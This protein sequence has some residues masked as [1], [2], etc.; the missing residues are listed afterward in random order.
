MTYLIATHDIDQ[1]AVVS[2]RDQRAE[3]G[4]PG[5]LAESFRVLFARLRLLGV[6]AA[7]PPFVIYHEFGPDGVDAEV[8]VPVV[9]A[10]SANGKVQSRVL[11]AATV[12]RTL[13]IGPYEELG[14]AYAELTDWI[15][16]HGFETAGPVHERYLN[17]PGDVASPADY[18]TEIEMPI[19]PRVVAV[20]A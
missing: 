13:H 6:D 10:I 8:C 7:G 16:D 4:I 9:E 20:P 18:R 14:S 19:V 12:A 11:P 1:Q 5:F 17:G 2:I 3:Q 15:L